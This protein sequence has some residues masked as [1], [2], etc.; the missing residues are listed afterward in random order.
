MEVEEEGGRRGGVNWT[1]HLTHYFISLV[2]CL[3]SRRL[4]EEAA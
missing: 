3:W 4:L 1:N 2:P